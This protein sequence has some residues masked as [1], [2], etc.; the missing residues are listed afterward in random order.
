MWVSPRGIGLQQF[1]T[2]VFWYREDIY[3]SK[4][5]GLFQLLRFKP[6]GL[7]GGLISTTMKLSTSSPPL[8]YRIVLKNPFD[9]NIYVLAV[10]DSEINIRKHWDYLIKTLIPQT[11]STKQSEN[12][13]TSTIDFN[14]E[15]IQF[16]LTKVES[17]AQVLFKSFIKSL[18]I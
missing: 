8:T 5:N 14:E 10:S 16:L 7:I 13:T 15:L 3:P 9:K 1:L 4:E 17:L 2:E 12:K 18:F 11:N 6:S